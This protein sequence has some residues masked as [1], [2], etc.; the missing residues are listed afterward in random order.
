MDRPERKQRVV[1]KT[2]AVKNFNVGIIIIF[3]VFIYMVVTVIVG[4]TKDHISIYEVQ[5]VS[6][7]MDNTAEA[8]IIRNEN[9]YYTDTA[10]YTNYYVRNG[11]RVAVGDTIYSIDESKNIYE[12][13]VDYDMNYTLSNDDIDILKDYVTNF[14][15]N[16]NGDNFSLVYDLKDNLSSE[17][18]NISDTYLLENL[19]E[20]VSESG[21]SLTFNVVYSNKAGTISFFNDNLTGLKAGDVSLSTFDRTNYKSNN[22]YDSDLKESGALVYKLIDEDAWSIVISLSKEQYDALSSKSSISFTIKNDDLQLTKPCKFFTK[23]EG[24]FAQVDMTEYLI[25]YIKYRFLD[26]ELNLNTDSGLKIPYTSI[27]TKNFYKIPSEYYI[28]NE[29]VEEYGFTYMEYDIA[30]KETSYVFV[31]TDCYYED[32]TEGY[33]YVDMDEFEYGQYVY[34]MDNETLFQVSVVGSL[35]GVYNTNKGYAVFRRIEKISENEDYCIVKDGVDKS[36]SAHDHIALH[37]DLID[38]NLQIY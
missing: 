36:I 28:Y 13:L 20:I 6:M 24:Y 14:N 26:I 7:S 32:E 19:N 15:S 3:M 16:Y 18:S 1:R 4:L 5:A 12:Y 2:S 29:Q 22:L 17:I 23:G 33:V 31:E 27:T 35:E 37:A 34:S 11:A 21:S 30:T 10:G 9:D 8:V 38:E 25:R